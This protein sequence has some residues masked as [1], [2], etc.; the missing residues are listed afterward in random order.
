MKK[1]NLFATYVFDNRAQRSG[2]MGD[3]LLFAGFLGFLI[4][5]VMSS[6][7]LY[8]ERARGLLQSSQVWH[9]F[10]YW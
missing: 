3:L 5:L 9:S 2:E 6:I 8:E 7:V 4:G 10:Y 1:A